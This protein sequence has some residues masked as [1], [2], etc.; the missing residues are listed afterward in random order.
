MAQPSPDSA[1]QFQQARHCDG[2]AADRE[3]PLN[4]LEL[5]PVKGGIDTFS[6]EDA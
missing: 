2:K 6:A 4:A 1:L 3:R 5:G